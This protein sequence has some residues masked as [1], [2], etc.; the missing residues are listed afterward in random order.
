LSDREVVQG[1]STVYVI[2]E[3][4]P[5]PAI[6][7]SI[8]AMFREMESTHSGSGAV[9]PSRVTGSKRPDGQDSQL[10]REYNGLS[11]SSNAN[12][13]GVDLD[14]SRR[15]NV[16]EVDHHVAEV[17]PTTPAD[18]LPQQGI[19]KNLLARWRTIEQQAVRGRDE[20]SAK[21]SSPAKRSQSTSRVEV[22]QRS[23]MNRRNSDEEEDGDNKYRYDYYHYYH[24]HYYYTVG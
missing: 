11:S 17:A 12:Q 16:D 1:S 14:R 7:R 15:H 6:T 10:R 3:E 24:Y 19:A 21:R 9:A 4:L 23:R 22:R 8:L 18:E 2:E 13:N 5:P 20:T